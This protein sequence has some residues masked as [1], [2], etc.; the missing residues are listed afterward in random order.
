MRS[1]SSI[2]RGG[3]REPEHRCPAPS[4]RG[5]RRAGARRC[6]L[7]AT[8]MTARG[9]RLIADGLVRS[10]RKRGH[11]LSTLTLTR[12]DLAPLTA[13]D[14][15]RCPVV[16]PT[17]PD[18]RVDDR[19]FCDQPRARV[20]MAAGLLAGP[21]RPFARRR[22]RPADQGRPGRAPRRP[23]IT[24]LPWPR[25]PTPPRSTAG[26]CRRSGPR[27]GT[28]MPGYP[29]GTVVTAAVLVPART[30]W[31]PVWRFG[32]WAGS[33]STALA[34]RCG[35][36][37]GVPESARACDLWPSASSS[38]D[39]HAHRVRWSAPAKGREGATMSEQPTDPTATNDAANP[40]AHDDHYGHLSVEDDPEGTTDVAEL[41][42]RHRS[43][44][45]G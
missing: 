14:A 27:P 30:W 17:V 20:L 19:W 24:G 4:N 45:Q 31:R 28:T 23:T 21:D 8:R 10:T 15:G 5:T 42:R 6:M 40:E 32:Y 37:G 38:R 7:P 11:A 34:D 12:R 33:S 35:S 16:D 26:R 25:W 36:A 44:D 3:P 9:R 22:A 41:D 29:S 13:I 1:A 39:P 2:H 18:L 43:Q